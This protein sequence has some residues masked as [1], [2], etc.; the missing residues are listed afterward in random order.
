MVPFEASNGKKG[1]HS[2]ATDQSLFTDK[3]RPNDSR[4]FDV[5]ATSTFEPNTAKTFDLHYADG[6]HLRGFEGKDVVKLGDYE[7]LAPFGVI[8]DCNSPDFN[9]VDGILGFGLPREYSNMPHPILFSI[10]A[11]NPELQR[12]FSFFSTDDEAEVQL[13]GY[14]PDTVRG[15]MWYVG[16]NDP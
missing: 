8:T 10:Q 5:K 15:T 3:Y 13:G 14:D 7:A 12:K 4:H 9:G 2:L 11:A 1:V 16:S 6:S